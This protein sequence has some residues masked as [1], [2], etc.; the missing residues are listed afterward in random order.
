MA[1]F[2]A[3]YKA[4]KPFLQFDPPPCVSRPRFLP[5]LAQRICI[6]S[7]AVPTCCVQALPLLLLMRGADNAS[8]LAP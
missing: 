8:R 6:P 2:Y 1:N 5:N 4:I 3:Q 7:L